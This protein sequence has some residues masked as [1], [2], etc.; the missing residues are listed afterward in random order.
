MIGRATRRQGWAGRPRS[1]TQR[2]ASAGVLSAREHSSGRLGAAYGR[3]SPFARGASVGLAGR[4]RF[5][6]R[7]V[8]SSARNLRMAPRTGIQ[9]D[10]GVLDGPP[11]RLR[12]RKEPSGEQ[13][14][15]HEARLLGGRPNPIEPPWDELGVAPSGPAQRRRR[16]ERHA[17]CDLAQAN[18]GRGH[19]HR[20][21]RR[22]RDPGTPAAVV[23]QLAVD[24]LPGSGSRSNQATIRSTATKW[25]AEP[26]ITKRCQT[27]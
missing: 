11:G 3:A 24:A 22:S 20:G 14:A 16:G 27:K 6:P 15:A 26:R 23:R 2:A 19:W 8:P 17:A 4:R 21:G 18:L 5:Q 7:K 25:H 13:S 9:Y 12:P 10:A 1:S